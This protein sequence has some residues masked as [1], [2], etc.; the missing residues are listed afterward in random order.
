MLFWDLLRST[1]LDWVTGSFP[2]IYSLGSTIDDSGFVGTVHG[3]LETETWSLRGSVGTCFASRYMVSV[4]MIGSSIC[5]STRQEP[6]EEEGLLSVSST[7]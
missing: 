4:I 7:E 5:W 2:A 1:P 3:A 6:T